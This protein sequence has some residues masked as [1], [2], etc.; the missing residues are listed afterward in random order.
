VAVSH[1]DT[2]PLSGEDSVHHLRGRNLG[3]A[4]VTDPTTVAVARLLGVLRE[5]DR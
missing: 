2:T 3:L 1:H 4:T 5:R